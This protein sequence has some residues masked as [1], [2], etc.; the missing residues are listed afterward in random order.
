MKT[1][2]LRNQL[3]HAPSFPF[4]GLKTIILYLSTTKK[5]IYHNLLSPNELSYFVA[6]K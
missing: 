3:E 6:F 2:H 5:Y 4:V 1:I